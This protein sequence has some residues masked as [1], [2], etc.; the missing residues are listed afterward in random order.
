MPHKTSTR[1]RSL[2]IVT[3]LILAFALWACLANK[4][5]AQYGPYYTYPSYGYYAYGWPNYY[6]NYTYGTYYRAPYSYGYVAPVA[7]YWAGYGY[8][9]AYSTYYAP[10]YSVG[11][12]PAYGWSYGPNC[13]W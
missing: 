4:A 8:A 11:Y 3:G 6:G 12:W 7:P 9:P 1:R 10:S 13:W 5:Q 2:R